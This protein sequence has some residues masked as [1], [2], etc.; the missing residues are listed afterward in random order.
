M[1]IQYHP[2]AAPGPWDSRPYFFDFVERMGKGARVH[3]S[4]ERLTLA[5]RNAQR[6]CALF[7]LSFSPFMA[8]S[9]SRETETTGRAAGESS[10]KSASAH[11]NMDGLKQLPTP[12][13]LTKI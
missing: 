5:Q 7:L 6:F 2:E 10:Q 12:T 1:S 11:V 9:P 4:L 8:C 3:M 13:A